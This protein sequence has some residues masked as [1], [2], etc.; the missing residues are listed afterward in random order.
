M[1]VRTLL[2]NYSTRKFCLPCGRCYEGNHELRVD[3]EMDRS[4][5]PAFSCKVW[6]TLWTPQSRYEVENG[7]GYLRIHYSSTLLQSVISWARCCPHT[8]SL[9]SIL[10]LSPH[11]CFLKWSISLWVT[12]ETHDFD[13]L[14]FLDQCCTV[15]DRTA[16]ASAVLNAVTN[17]AVPQ[18]LSGESV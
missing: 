15:A 17:A 3:E 7:I 6:G 1:R 13:V 18:S 12:S 4:V 5:I 16:I 10:I 11:V 2:S 8:S 9:I 14:M